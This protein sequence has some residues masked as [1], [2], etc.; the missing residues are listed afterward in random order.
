MKLD[1]ISQANKKPGE[2]I[3]H[4]HNIWEFILTCSGEGYVAVED[5]IFPFK[6]GTVIC[7][8]P[9]KL[10]YNYSDNRYV[11]IPIRFSGI[12]SPACEEA[13]S[14]QDDLDATFESLAKITLKMFYK[15]ENGSEEILNSLCE[16]LCALLFKAI[17]NKKSNPEIEAVKDIFISN[18]TDPEFSVSNALENLNYSQAHFR[19]LFKSEMQMTPN[20]YL[21]DLRLSYAKKLLENSSPHYE[22]VSY[23]ALRSGF[24][25]QHYFSRIFKK[26][27]GITP[28]QYRKNT[29]S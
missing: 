13:Y 19:K 3:H 29:L 17:S 12:I 1:F 8:P 15:P 25:D 9:G 4:T 28:M 24:Y 22:K 2:S 21:N 23:V 7:V 11:H 14:F 20:T 10:H 26:K 6:K 5:K 16:A 18:F 27:Y